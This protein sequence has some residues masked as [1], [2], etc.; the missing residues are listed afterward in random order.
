[1]SVPE[2]TEQKLMA[3]LNWCRK[4]PAFNSPNGTAMEIVTHADHLWHEIE[5]ERFHE[6]RN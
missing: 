6:E 1:M 5:R 3:F 2:K 4:R